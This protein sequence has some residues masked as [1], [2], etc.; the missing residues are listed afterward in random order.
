MIKDIVDVTR[1]L[2]RSGMT[3]LI[4]T[5]EVRFAREVA[6]QVI[7]FDEG[8]IAEEGS[9]NEFFTNPKSEHAKMFLS[10]ILH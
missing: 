5:H 2:A 9:P 10:Q 8:M 6:N 7:M 4:V 3:M 1:E